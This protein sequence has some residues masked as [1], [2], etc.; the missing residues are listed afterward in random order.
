M[1]LSEEME[2]ELLKIYGRQPV[3]EAILAGK[4]VSKVWLAKGATGKIIARIERQCL[5]KEIPLQKTGKNDLQKI[6]GAVVHQ[7]VA[8]EMEFNPYI[9]EDEFNSLVQERENITVLILDQIQDSHNMG[10]ILRTAEITATDVIVIPEK[11]SAG[12]NATIAKT[13]VGALFHVPIYSAPD[14]MGVINF[15]KGKEIMVYAAVGNTEINIYETD[16]SGGT[17]IIIG[18]EGK[19]VR[20]N[21]ANLCDAKIA[22]PQ[23]GRINSLNASVSTAVILYELVRQRKYGK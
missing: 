19:G 10:A 4:N 5:L 7:N 3:I 23:F 15:L 8:A 16:F 14:L 1:K 2:K 21:I 22:I 12:V 20:K 11:G 13:S 18:S 17:A 6:V 9:S